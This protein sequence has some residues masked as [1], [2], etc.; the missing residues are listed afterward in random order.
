MTISENTEHCV[1]FTIIRR[2]IETL[3]RTHR[4]KHFFWWNNRLIEHWVKYSRYV[5]NCN[6][7]RIDFISFERF[8]HIKK[9]IWLVRFWVSFFTLSR[10]IKGIKNALFWNARFCDNTYI[11][12]DINVFSRSNIR[13]FKAFRNF[14]FN[15]FSS[16]M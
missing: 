5:S 12:D 8:Y 7:E 11:I 15:L 2:K 10:S 1:R 3:F 13:F 4:R 14:C 6:N 9:T 16:L